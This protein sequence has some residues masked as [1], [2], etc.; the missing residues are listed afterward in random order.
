MIYESKNKLYHS[1]LRKY[2]ASNGHGSVICRSQPIS[3]EKEKKTKSWEPKMEVETD[4]W[5]KLTHHPRERLSN[6][7]QKCFLHETAPSAT[8]LPFKSHTHQ[9]LRYKT[10]FQ[11]N[12][13]PQRQNIGLHSGGREFWGGNGSSVFEDRPQIPFLS[14]YF[15]GGPRC[16]FCSNWAF[17]LWGL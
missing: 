5:L 12:L 3:Q 7:F 17:V 13:P 1:L 9:P 10:Q 16:F 8:V 14:T 6:H 4:L 2:Y 15:D 11:A